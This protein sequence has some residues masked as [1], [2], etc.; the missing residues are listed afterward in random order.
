MQLQREMQ[1]LKLASEWVLP[2]EVR[3]RA[4]SVLFYVLDKSSL[5][6]AGCGFFISPT[7]ALTVSHARVS[8]CDVDEIK[9]RSFDGVDLTLAIRHD[10]GDGDANRVPG[11]SNLDFMVLE[12]IRGPS[13]PKFFPI[14]TLRSPASL[15]GNK[16]VALLA[17]GIA[18]ADELATAERGPLVPLSL[19]VTPVSVSNSGARH[20]VYY[21]SSWDGDSGGC[22]FFNGDGAVVGIHLEGVNRAKELLEHAKDLADVSAAGISDGVRE[23]LSP[24]PLS[25][26]S[27]ESVQKRS[28]PAPEEMRLGVVEGGI[29]TVSASIRDIVST[30]TTGGLALFLGCKEVLDAVEA[31]RSRR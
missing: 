6:P 22:L 31:V 9:G 16:H 3:D 18:M 25:P 12:I 29:R 26:S 8:C 30:V 14:T 17:G 24:P 28:K 20:F 10:D 21:S 27:S 5:S 19:T 7:L 23:L 1:A 15:V 4:S 2:P 13:R 11:K